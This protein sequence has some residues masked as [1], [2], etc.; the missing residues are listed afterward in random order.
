MQRASAL[1]IKLQFGGPDL[2]AT[3]TSFQ[4][5]SNLWLKIQITHLLV[6][7]GNS[8]GQCSPITHG[9]LLFD[10]QLGQYSIWTPFLN[11]IKRGRKK[12]IQWPQTT[13][14]AQSVAVA[15]QTAF[16]F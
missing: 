5:S 7:L 11:N 9:D 6:S 1:K 10:H 8:V 14:L 12:K 3:Q 16:F 2:H 13:P 15:Q 4:V